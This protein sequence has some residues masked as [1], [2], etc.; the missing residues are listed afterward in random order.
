MS[1][2]KG[3]IYNI[4]TMRGSGGHRIAS[5]LRL[6][7]WDIEV[8]DYVLFFTL[9]ELKAYTKSRIDKDVKFIGI[10]QLFNSW[11]DTVIELLAWIKNTYPE[12]KIISGSPTFEGYKNNIDYFIIGWGETALLALLEW[13]FSNG[14]RPIM[15]DKLI[16]ANI[17]YRAAPHYSPVIIYENRDFIQ[18]GEWLGIEFSRGCKFACKFCSNPMI[19]I[20]DDWS[21]SSESVEIQLKDAY[22]RFGASQYVVSDD[23]FNDREEKILKFANVVQSLDFVPY[24]SG[25]IRPDL[26]VSRKT[27]KENLLRMNFVGHFYGVESFNHNSA[28]TIRKGID[29]TKLQEGILDARKYFLSNGSGLYRGTMSFIAGLPG[30]TADTLRTTKQWLL[31]NWKEE[32]FI[33][34]PLHISKQGISEL[35]KNYKDYGYREINKDILSEEQK[36]ITFKSESTVTWENDNMNFLEALEYSNDMYN[37]L[38]SESFSIGNFHITYI[39]KPIKETIS[40][41]RNPKVYSEIFFE[42]DTEEFN[43]VYNF[44]KTYFNSKMASV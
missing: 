24:F 38:T 26:L 14:P 36:K 25:F 12:I 13:L 39:P 10:S 8:L 6:N 4:S 37:T 29:T 15:F 32:N 40:L 18:P 7:N 16:N 35:D 5:E 21:R 30:E 27:D 44:A 2:F 34:Y 33:F 20:Q 28:K 31:D 11:P 17:N 23:T 42:K 22:D 43:F 1:K 41:K 3:L 19:G 9:E